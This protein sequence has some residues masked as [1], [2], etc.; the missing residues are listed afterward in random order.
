MNAVSRRDPR[1]ARSGGFALPLA[2]TVSVVVLVIGLAILEVGRVDTD[3]SVKSVHEVQARAAAELGLERAQAMAQSQTRPWTVMTYNDRYLSFR[4]TDD[5]LY[6]GNPVC[7]LWSNIPAGGGTNVTYTVVIENLS[8]FLPTSG[9]YRIHAFGM[10]GNKTRHM[11]MD[12]TTVTYASFGW[13]TNHEQSASG[14]RIY[15][16]DGDRIDGWVYTNDQ[17]NIAGSPVFE[18]KVNSAASSI[19]YY[20]GGPP[21]DN[22]DFQGGIELNSPRID[23][24]GMMNDGHISSVR[25]RALETDGI[26]LDSN[27]GRPYAITFNSNGTITVSKQEVKTNRRGRVTGTK[28]VTIMKNKPL[29]TTNG[30]IY[31][32]EEV[33]IKG[34]VKGNVTLATP[35]GKDIVITQDLVYAYP[36]NKKKV[37]KDNWNYEDPKFVDKIG[38]IS[39]GDI[40]LDKN[41]SSDMYVMASFAAVNGSFRNENYQDGPQKTLHLYG[42]LAQDRRGPVGTFGSRGGTG[43]LKDYTYDDR[44]LTSPPPHYQPLTYNFTQW[45]LS[46]PEN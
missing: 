43:Y 11:M 34:T 33:Q 42:G 45:S 19:H 21:R 26:H 35:Q 30:A 2:M 12:A 28:W 29:S 13:L 37:F 10:S 8:A 20:R 16:A 32:E 4:T 14:G 17:L 22:P 18:D 24:G 23:I 25:E 36:S 44:F 31:C 39:G 38:L 15:F 1:C 3:V 46:T 41:A 9:S 7:T 6:L 40:V 5:P 27:G